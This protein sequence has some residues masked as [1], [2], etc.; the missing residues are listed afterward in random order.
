MARKVF[1]SFHYERDA[2][3]AG[4][5]RNHSVT[6]DGF[7]TAGYIDG[8]EWES[9]KRQGENAIKRWI[10]GQLQNTTVTVVLIG[11]ETANRP[12]VRYEIEK[13]RERKNG[14][15]GIRIHNIKDFR[16]QQ[17]DFAGQDPFV[18]IGYQGV[19]VYD[20]VNDYGYANFPTWVE[21]AIQKW[22]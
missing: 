9:I 2:G 17:T 18:S 20:W 22:N 21:A 1:F 3:R 5:V 4:V 19:K 10:D 16:T 15:L 14:L 12:W 6:K 13:S 8:V 11:A 7:Q